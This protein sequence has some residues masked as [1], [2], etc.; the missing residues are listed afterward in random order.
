M[1][2]DLVDSS[3]SAAPVTVQAEQTPSQGGFARGA[4]FG[5]TGEVF[6]GWQSVRELEGS[7]GLV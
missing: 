7:T 4:V 3:A 6:G 1:L 5:S 2:Q